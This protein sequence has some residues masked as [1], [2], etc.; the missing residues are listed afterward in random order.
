[1]R[2][3][4]YGGLAEPEQGQQ[5]AER[6]GQHA[7]GNQAVV[8]G[9]AVTGMRVG[10]RCAGCC[11]R[12]GVR[13]AL[14]GG[15]VPIV[16]LCMGRMGQAGGRGMAGM[17]RLQGPAHYRGD[18][19]QY[20]SGHGQVQPEG[21]A[22]VPGPQPAATAPE[23]A[24]RRQQAGRVT[25]SRQ[26]QGGTAEGLALS[27]N[28]AGRLSDR[29]SQVPGRMH[30]G[31]FAARQPG[32]AGHFNPAGRGCAVQ[33]GTA[34]QT[35]CRSG[36]EARPGKETMPGP[37]AVA[38][39]DNPQLQGINVLRH[40]MRISKGVCVPIVDVVSVGGAALFI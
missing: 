40:E 26:G 25:G 4:G 32:N 10:C 3:D 5:Q 15:T 27:G 39:T 30:A 37:G 7:C 24:V 31:A 28:P 14:L 16:L 33:A 11:W 29:L 38:W 22:F 20:G 21:L 1:M 17:Q 36:L 9:R 35:R 34:L 2:R 19:H 6:R 8:A 18:G 12:S 23:P 13:L